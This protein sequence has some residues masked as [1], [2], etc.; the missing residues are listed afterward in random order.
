MANY[1]RKKKDASAGKIAHIKTEIDGIVFHSKMESQY[2]IKLK[3][4]KE[5]GLIQDFGLQPE[6]VLLEPYIIVEGETIYKSDERFNKLKRKTKAPTVRG[7]SYI[8]DFYIV[9]NDGTSYIVDTKGVS[10]KDFE[11]KK[12]LFMALYPQYQLEVIIYD[13]VTD[14]WIDFYEYQKIERARKAE[15]KAI[16]EA[17][18]KEKAQA[19]KAP[20]RARKKA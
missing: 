19:T 15:R 18:A 14:D 8:G 6:F 16:K 12:K 17:K 13:K 10:T 2:Y 11:I 9:K 7:I 3:A 20:T 1:R 4:D 5:A